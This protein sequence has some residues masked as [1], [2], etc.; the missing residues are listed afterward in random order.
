MVKGIPGLGNVLDMAKD[1]GNFFYNCY[2]TYGSIFRIKVFNVTYKVL[3][4]PEAARFMGSRDGRGK[5]RSREY[6]EGLRNTFH[7]K[8]LIGGEDGEIHKQLR[9]VMKS[10][11]SKKALDGK[12]DQFIQCSDEMFAKDWRPGNPVY[13]VAAMQRLVTAQLGWLLTSRVPLDYVEDIR[14]TIRNILNVLVTRQRPKIL[15][16]MPAYKRAFKRVNELGQL[17]IEDY[18][19]NKGKKPESEKTLIDDIMEEHERN[20]DLIPTSDL[21]LLLT[22]PYVAGLDTVANTTASMVYLVLK[23]PEVYRQIQR[24]VDAVFSRPGP[25]E[26]S[27]LKEMPTL[28]GAIMESMRLYP[29][30]AASMRVANTDFAYDNYAVKEGELLYMG[31]TVPHHMEEFYRDPTKFDV[32]RYSLERAEHMQS[33]AYSPFG[34]GPHTCLGKTLA[35]VQMMLSMARLFYRLDLQLEPVDYRIK[36]VTAPTPGPARSFKVKVNGLRNQGVSE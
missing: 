24:E 4:G 29:V 12:H 31:I 7:A 34:R 23:H 11:F 15:L 6:W 26:E 16:Q 1:P 36:I 3:A 2:R 10:G 28:Q 27:S 22:G 18:Y 33:G 25:F 9:Q 19:A 35:D 5:L 30:A 32:H 17:M 13:V 21:I 20:T 8:Y 14:I